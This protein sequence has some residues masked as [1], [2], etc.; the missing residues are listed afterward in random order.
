MRFYT[1]SL[2]T[3]LLGSSVLVS[4]AQDRRPS[5]TDN[6]PR[7]GANQPPPPAPPPR[8]PSTNGTVQLMG[9]TM[10]LPASVRTIDGTENNAANPEWGS[11]DTE[12]VRLTTIAYQDGTNAPS[13]ADRPSPREISNA[14][15]AQSGSQPN[16]AGA[17]DFLWQWGQFLDHDIDLSA[18]MDPAEPFPVTVP[19]GDP[20]FDPFSTGIETIP[21]NRSFYRIVDGVRQQV[22][23][24]TAFIDGSNVYGSDDA[25]AEELRTL[26]GT[27]KLKTSA[28]DLLPFNTNAF[29]NA[30]TSADAGYFLA[31]D[32]RANEQVYL[33][34]MHTLF[35]R[36]HNHWADTIAA[37]NP[38]FDGDTLFELARMMVVAELQAITYNEFLPTLLGPRPLPD[39]EGYD[40][41]VDP[42]IANVFSAAAYRFGH[43]MLSSELLRLDAD[44][45]PIAEGNLALANAFFSP[46]EIVTH[47]IEPYL[48]GLAAQAAQEIDNQV[49]DDVRNFLFGTPGSGGLDLASLNIQRGRDHGLP[50]YNQVRVNYG[51]PPVTSFADINADITVQA[52]LA[53]VYESVNDIDPWVGCLAEEHLPGALVGETAFIIFADQFLS[54]RDGDRYFYRNDLPPELAN[55]VE[56]ETLARIIRRNTDIGQEIQENVFRVGETELTPTL[57]AFSMDNEDGSAELRWHSIPGQSYTILCSRDLEHWRPITNDCPSE[58]WVTEMVD[59]E[60]ADYR[61]WFYQIKTDPPQTP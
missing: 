33:S 48:R 50:G 59:P 54:L 5:P 15:A 8:A 43:T 31:G 17:S 58:G 24:I 28:G 36:E 38:G 52:R 35:A 47:G 14:V 26:D 19:T 6:A 22:N 53:T 29:A 46:E 44:G 30:P 40:P 9:V 18:E 60:A 49:V 11:A 34:A 7:R 21:L 57:M 41:S 16:S 2:C 45:N 23:E 13:G 10:P 3:A 20:W 1:V 42:G 4:N 25:R 12:L 61:A 37:D 55:R 39:Y 32:F 56:A 27:G 51:L